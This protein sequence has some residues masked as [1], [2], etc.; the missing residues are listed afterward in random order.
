MIPAASYLI[1]VFTDVCLGAQHELS[2][3]V[4]DPYIDAWYD[5]NFQENADK[6]SILPK[7]CWGLVQP[8]EPGIACF[9]VR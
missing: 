7:E 4:T 8:C 1:S 2:E 5:G 9:P 3:A 6:V